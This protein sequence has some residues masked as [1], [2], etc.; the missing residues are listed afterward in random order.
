MKQR[1]HQGL[2]FVASLQVVLLS[3]EEEL[4]VVAEIIHVIPKCMR[5]RQEDCC[6]F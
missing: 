5:L 2:G 4:G 6:E 3:E 1:R